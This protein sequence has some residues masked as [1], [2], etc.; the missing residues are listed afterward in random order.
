MRTINRT[1]PRQETQRRGTTLLIVVA[2][3]GL[4]M[5]TG[6]VFFTFAAQERATAEYFSEAAKDAVSVNDDPFPFALRQILV[7]PTDNE[8]QSIL[9]SPRRRLSLVTNAVGYD[10]VPFN[11]V[12][13]NVVANGAGV[14]F[15][16]NDFDGTADSFSAAVASPLNF[17]DALTAWSSSASILQTSEGQLQNFR[18]RTTSFP[19][20]DVDYTYPD[21]NNPLIAYN[22][23]AIR[24]NGSAHV[25]TVS[26]PSRFERVPVFIPSGMRPSLLKSGTG[27]GPT[28]NSTLT[29]EEWYDH[30][31]AT[32]NPLFGVRSLR[33]SELHIAGLDASGTPVRRYI[34][35]MNPAD[36]SLIAT[37]GSFPLRPNEDVNPADFGQLGVFTGH[38][39]G[40]FGAPT[41]FR[42]D[43]DNT[44]DGVF[45]GI[46]WDL[47]YPVQETA[48]GEV[49]GTMFS[50]TIVDAGGLL[51]L[52]SHGNLAELR[53]N[54]DILSQVAGGG[55]SSEMNTT[56]LSASNQGLGPNE[57]SLL[58]ALA[59]EAFHPTDAAGTAASTNAAFS[60]WYNALPTNAREQ[61]NM[62]LLWLLTGRVDSGTEEVFDGRWGDAS[63]LW[64]HRFGND[65]SATDGDFEI[66]SLPRPGRAGNL[67]QAST[68][69]INFGGF[70]GFDDNGNALEGI[71]STRFGR[72]RG[73]VH[74]LDV[75]GTG[76]FH[77][78]NDPRLP[79]LVQPDMMVPGN[80]PGYINYSVV[81]STSNI[82]SDD[83][84]LSGPD[85]DFTTTTDNL[86]TGTRF[87]L[88]FED[89]L[90]T[91]MD[92][93]LAIRPD[94][95]IY[96]PADML[97]GHLS[98]TDVGSATTQLSVRLTNLGVEAFST[99]S[100]IGD[101]F[102]T[103]LNSLRSV[104]HRQDLGVD[105]RP[106]DPFVD[107]DGDGTTDELDEVGTAGTDD[108]P[109]AW[110]WNADFDGFDTDNDGLPDGDGVPNFPPT[111][112][113]VGAYIQGDLNNRRTSPADPFRPVVRNLLRS[114]SGSTRELIL[115]LPLSVN[116]ILDVNRT[117]ETP[118]ET[119]SQ[120]L[121][122]IQRA[123]MRLRPL[124]EHP[125][126]DETLDSGNTVAAD[127]TTI[128]QVGTTNGTTALQEF[129][130]RTA[131]RREFWARRDRQ[132]LARD[133]YVLLYTIG[134]GE[135]TATG[136]IVDATGDNSGR[137]I[138]SNHQLRRMAQFAV[139]M[140]D[141][142]DTDN[143]VTKFEYDK[144]LNSGW[145]L[146][147]DPSTDDGYTASV[148]GTFE[149][150][151]TGNNG[152]GL[153]PE[154][155]ADDR[156]V[157][158]GVEAQQLSLSEALA[159][160]SPQ[161]TADQSSTVYDD[162]VAHRAFLHL[163][164]QN[165]QPYP[166]QLSRTEVGIADEDKALWRFLRVD[167]DDRTTNPSAA[168]APQ[169]ETVAPK[170]SLMNG[171]ADVSGGDVFTIGIAATQENPTDTNP[172]GFSS[173]DIYLDDD[174]DGQ[175]TLI[176]PDV[177]LQTATIA[178]GTTPA[179]NLDLDTI[180]TTHQNR[181]LVDGA[182]NGGAFL[183][184]IREPMSAAPSLP[185][186]AGNDNYGFG[187]VGNGFEIVMQRRQ[188][189]NLPNLPL[190]ENP[191]IEVDRIFVPLETLTPNAVNLGDLRSTERVE[192]L[193]SLSA[194]Q[195]SHEPIAAAVNSR[196]NS[197]GAPL[198]DATDTSGGPGSGVDGI[199]SF[200]LWQPHFDRDFGSTVELFRLPVIGPRLLTQRLNRMRYAAY[201]QAFPN[202]LTPNPGDE[203]ETLLSS[204]VSMFLQ[205]DFPEGAG[206]D[207]T[208]SGEA[209]DNAWYRLL[210]FVEVPS[211][212]NTMLGNY[213]TRQRVPGKININAIRHVEVYAGLIDDETLAR[214]PL[215][216]TPE[217]TSST[218]DTNNRF[219]PFMAEATA[220]AG[221]GATAITGVASTTPDSHRD[222]WFEMVAERD[223]VNLTY[224]PIS[225]GT[226]NFWIPNSITSRP[227]RSLGYRNPDVGS[228]GADMGL[229]E[230]ILRQ[231]SFDAASA[232]PADNR[233][234]LEVGDR[235]GHRNPATSSTQDQRHQIASKIFNNTTTIS[236]TF[237]IYGTAAYFKAF[238]D[239][240]GLYRL[241]RRIGLDTDG[242]GTE[243]DDP[244]WEQRAVFVIDRSDLLNAYDEASGNFD[245]QRLIKYRAD[246]QSDGQ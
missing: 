137:A 151:Q 190:T 39:P 13:Q 78:V 238:E 133:I 80:W 16:D 144:D 101:R 112:G 134:G 17:V 87:N 99:S 178:A 33:P 24:D 79:Q 11:G 28:G 31:V 171:N 8:K 173:S 7:G 150:I 227:F 119:S 88:R 89:S 3:L 145:N 53:R 201:Q 29:D 157:V 127:V 210:Q 55:G 118:L 113:T 52:N 128:P 213:L 193:D 180:H 131:A 49:Y 237:I 56:S 40:A 51:D 22:G 236:N 93:D 241:G 2:L 126:A 168:N 81:G 1:L 18:G 36:A 74:P 106:G 111:F 183:E 231:S 6:M 235:A 100:D 83:R 12:G 48:G 158:Y 219:M 20:P 170:L 216:L 60:D 5:F 149:P 92:L 163:E 63:A 70:N 244:G 176:S 54:E 50:F 184:E 204:A 206:N 67:V 153:Y 21:I 34:D 182:N 43:S 132:Q 147:D 226:Q 159:I 138:Y 44:G 192:A 208:T 129:P 188:N 86:I 240:S 62:Q 9:W 124:T 223:G 35:Q 165:M 26:R 242:N 225:N 154:D 59:A 218:I 146:D 189:P 196:R 90:E 191:F 195:G 66:A 32:G 141:A 96:N 224:D 123:G 246:L 215:F 221:S 97:P 122:Y 187:A 194:T 243:E 200:S 120:F 198:N 57:V 38:D 229:D 136:N 85:Q 233:S 10:S 61:A 84:Y 177:G 211:R 222:R 140:V 19:A 27:N 166:I 186:Y 125:D 245:W 207:P 77:Q 232:D 162:S 174:N 47:G 239:P 164:V 172:N 14:P 42:L 104:I 202:L 25:P 142:M 185:M 203:D 197:I 230:T 121:R 58:H 209:E 109:R 205:P 76:R 214:V 65:G 45:E 108:G 220:F 4:L 15:I 115:Q 94:D 102:T 105:G 23:W 135:V 46:W 212:V 72:V 69:P 199:G 91:V 217:N 179:P 148:A 73:F 110:E 75:G 181:F 98:A 130:P 107:D 156:G 64:F 152:N 30:S 139:N 82:L 114:A 175:F 95:S 155:S 167:R 169:D 228:N 71:A 143:V 116:Q 68:A 41:G 160:Y 103:V 234:W 117:A 161:E 37:Y